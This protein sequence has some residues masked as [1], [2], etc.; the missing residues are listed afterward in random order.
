MSSKTSL[1]SVW[2]RRRSR[3]ALVGLLSAMAVLA[4]SSPAL[5]APPV[6]SVFL[7]QF[8]SG[9]SGDGQFSLPFGVAVDPS[10][11]EVYVADELNNR[12]ERFSGVGGYLSQFGTSGSGDGQLSSPEGVAVDP[13]SHDVYVADVDNNRVERFSSAG[14]YL[15]QFGTSGSGDGQFS[16]PIGVAVDPSSRDVYVIDAGNSRVERFSPDGVAYLSQFG[17]SGSGDGQFSFPIGVAIDASS[18]DVYVVDQND[19]RVERFSAAGVYLSQFGGSGVGGGTFSSPGGAAF[20]PATGVLYVADQA[21]DLVEFF[22]RGPVVSGAPVDGGTVYASRPSQV[23]RGPFSYTYQWLDCPS[24]GGACVN[25]GAAS[26]SSGLRLKPGDVGQTIEVQVTQTSASGTVGPV[27]SPAVGPVAL[28]PP[29]NTTLPV[30]SG[31]TID[32]SVLTAKSGTWG[33]PGP[34]V[35]SYT[36]QWQSCS[37]G[38]CANVGTNASGYRL[39]PGDVGHTIQVQVSATNAD[40][41]AAPVTSNAVGPV[42]GS[43]PVNTTAPSITGTYATGSRLIGHAGT[44]SGVLPISYTYQ[45]QRCPTGSAGSCVDIPGATVNSYRLTAADTHVRLAVSATNGD[46]GPVT[47][48]SAIAP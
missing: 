19:P 43:P 22:G 15:S 42:T 32:G 14:V 8:G 36:Y 5:A 6:A 2:S 13:S 44:W 16:F 23:G 10:S 41:T 3:G 7:G 24:G 38:T 33:G 27:T 17:T 28:S 48:Y 12:V 39:A 11:G 20:D 34:P 1:R 26:A 46:G 4:G 45:W 25:N 9:G 31:S 30:V 18:G 37:G 47:A 21:N 29:V 35:T 40:G